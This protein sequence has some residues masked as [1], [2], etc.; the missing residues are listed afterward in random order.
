MPELCT[1]KPTIGFPQYPGKER[2]VTREP[3]F[4][5]IY[6]LFMFKITVDCTIDTSFYIEG[7]VFLASP[8]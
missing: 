6:S 2:L 8:F 5:Y 4:N 1:D 7:L 3:H